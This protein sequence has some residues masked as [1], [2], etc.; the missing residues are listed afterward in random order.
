M[1][2][3][4]AYNIGLAAIILSASYW[5]VAAR[6][7]WRTDLLLAARIALLITLI[8]YPWDFF[9]IQLAVWRYPNDPGPTIH[10]VPINDLVFIWLCT[11]FA[12]IVLQRFDGRKASR[13]RHSKR[14]NAGK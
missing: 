10:G 9:A 11:Y 3:Y 12:S 7:T 6:K 2:S 5:L 13:E 4:A 1:N 8:S 14:E